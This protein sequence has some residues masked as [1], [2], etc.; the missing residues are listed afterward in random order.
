LLLKGHGEVQSA[1][2][3]VEAAEM[4]L[5]RVVHASQ[6][7][8]P[9]ELM[10]R[11]AS[12]EIGVAA[13]PSAAAPVEAQ[14]PLLAFPADFGALVDL[15]E[16]SRQ[17]RLAEDLRIRVRLVRYEPPELVLQPRLALDPEFGRGLG[18]ALREITGRRWDLTFADGPAQP[19]LI[20]QEQASEDAARDAILAHP[21]VKAVMEAFPAAEYLGYSPPEP[22]PSERSARA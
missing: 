7:P 2:L 8:D 6:L 22:Q 14:A 21:I 12:G 15:V 9:G 5:L 20:E 19:S 18:A 11:I 16:R 13:A 17:A 10:K 4:A 3:P 1:S